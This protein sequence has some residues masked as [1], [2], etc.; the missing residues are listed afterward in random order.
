MLI[1]RSGASRPDPV[2]AAWLYA[3]I[4]RWGQAVLTDELLGLAQAVFRPDLY[5]AA[6][7]LSPPPERGDLPDA[8]GAFIG[9]RFEAADIANYLSGWRIRRPGRPRLSLVR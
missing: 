2:Q 6:L 3:Q 5:D 1:G 4:V 7:G 9:P 8:I